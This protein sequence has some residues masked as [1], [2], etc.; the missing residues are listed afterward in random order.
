VANGTQAALLVGDIEQPQ[1]AALVAAA[2]TGGLA[3]DALR[4]DWLLVPHHG[5]KTSSSDAFLAAVQPRLAVVQAGYRN[6]FGHP[7]E[8]VL[9][10]YQAR[11]A[12]VVD[13]ARCGAAWW[14]SAQPQQVECQRWVGLRY[15]H[16]PNF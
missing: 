4:A 7:A 6:R 13:T 14:R 1:E 3:A 11:G 16:H 2:A 8:P 9:A 5:S 15:W 10:R 12:E